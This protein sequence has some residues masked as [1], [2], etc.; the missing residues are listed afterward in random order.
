M[1]L[2]VSRRTDIPAF[3]AEWFINRLKDKFAH[4][5]NPM[6]CH[7]ISEIPLT[8]DNVDC[9]VFWTKDPEPLL[10]YLD[11]IDAMG[12]KYY[13]QFTITPYGKSIEPNVRDKKEIIQTFKKLS[14][15][16]GKDKVIL[17]YDPIFITDKKYNVEYHTKMFQRLCDQLYQHTN[18]VVISF[19]D[20]Y[21][22]ICKNIQ[23]MGI[24][25][26]EEQEMRDLASHF[27]ETAKPYGLKIE[28][29]A[30]KIDLK[31]LGIDH[32]HCI[33]GALIEKIIGYKIT[34][35][36]KDGKEL[37][38]G[39]RADCGC[40]KCIDI[41]QYNTC[42][43]GCLYCYANINKDDAKKNHQQHSPNSPLLLGTKGDKDTVIPRKEKDTNS[44]REVVKVK[45]I[46]KSNDI[47]FN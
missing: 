21:S 24:K 45:I 6:N 29:C 46:C 42:V 11:D 34:R 22:K 13:F 31:E 8:P 32:S 20:G 3:Y 30:E 23:A 39:E 15:K 27:A 2:S 1:I 43:H 44:L 18:R 28:T 9:I 7:Q 4:V 25:A 41:G 35:T 38:D 19:L 37:R 26:P 17:R 5:R 16:I 14:D 33:D 10:R 47:S 36:N 12:Y 40:M